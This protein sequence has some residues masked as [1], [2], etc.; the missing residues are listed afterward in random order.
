MIFVWVLL[1]IS[2]VKIFSTLKWKNY[3]LLF[4]LIAVNSITFYV[5]INEYMC[6]YSV[7]KMNEI[8]DVVMVYFPSVV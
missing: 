4:K 5:R 6:C 8:Q 1:F 2:T 3:L 7:F